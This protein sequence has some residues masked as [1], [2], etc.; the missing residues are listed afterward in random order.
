MSEKPYAEI[1]K[2]E[3]EGRITK[4]RQLMEKQN[5]DGL[6]LFCKENQIYYGGW[7]DT[8]DYNFL[9]AL[10]LPRKG[11]VTFI[12]PNHVNFGVHL[13]TYIEEIKK[14]EELVDAMLYG[15]KGSDPCEAVVKTIQELELGD[16]KI[17]LELGYGMY[18][19]TA[20][21]NEIDR[22]RGLLP[23]AKFVDATNMIW[24]QRMFKTDWEFDL[25][26]RL[27]KITAL[28][29]KAGLEAAGEGVTELQVQDA[30]WRYYLEVG[31]M[32][33]PMQGGVIIRVHP[34]QEYFPPFTGRALNRPMRKGDQLM[35]DAGPAYKGY[36]TDMQRQAVIGPPDDLQKKLA[37]LATVGYEA[38][39]DLLKPGTPIKDLPRAA[40]E[41]QGKFDPNY[42]AIWGF[43]GHGIG[44][45]IHEPPS[46][47]A[48][49][50]TTLKP[51]MVLTVEVTGYDRPKWRVM[52]A[53][54]ED[55]YIIT[56]SGH[57]ILTGD[58]PRKLW[59]R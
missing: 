32:D 2:S 49:E 28:G 13:Y 40:L 19:F 9:T 12:G 8:W 20:T 35:L 38:V 21:I 59:V 16:K 42:S 51:K 46:L 44:L 4:A 33:T 45:R 15:L 11:P 25:Y 56:E 34:Y 6:L 55:M 37:D 50:E 30:I 31:I 3:F 47:V 27:C 1:P 57:E 26:R 48:H 52:G 29:F 54:P 23:K 24:E 14:Y 5:I 41:A 18:P 39:I 7:R 36:Y 22:I 43:V 53:F 17:G 58:C 10:I